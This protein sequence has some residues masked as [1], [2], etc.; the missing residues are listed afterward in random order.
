MQK[1]AMQSHLFPGGF[2]YTKLPLNLIYINANGNLANF[3]RIDI[4]RVPAVV[5]DE[6]QFFACIRKIWS[7][8]Q[9]GT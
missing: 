4:L 5:Y 1:K 3:H 8:V 9:K 7:N 2:F 6:M